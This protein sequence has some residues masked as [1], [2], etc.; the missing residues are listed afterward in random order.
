MIHCAISTVICHAR[1]GSNL[2][3]PGC[4]F[5]LKFST[6]CENIVCGITTLYTLFVPMELINLPTD[7]VTIMFLSK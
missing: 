5:I 2:G 6:C 1:F 4:T 3:H 7:I